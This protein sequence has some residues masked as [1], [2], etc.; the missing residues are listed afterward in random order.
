M[1]GELT[2]KILRELKEGP[3]DVADLMRAFL[4]AGY[5]ASM[6]SI[7]NKI[8]EYR[9]KRLKDEEER[10]LFLKMRQRF[11]DFKRSLLR[12]DLITVNDKGGFK[13]STK[14]RFKLKA[15]E[16]RNDERALQLSINQK[17]QIN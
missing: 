17:V 16:K 6:R 4:S 2:R 3:Q 9:R 12:D 13:L 11:Y 1:K 15:L 7:D 8:Y 5:G 10:E 14:G